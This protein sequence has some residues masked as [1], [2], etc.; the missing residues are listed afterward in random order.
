MLVFVLLLF[1]GSIY[2]KKYGS[3]S[4][5]ISRKKG[6]DFSGND[7]SGKHGRSRVEGEL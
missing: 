6:R 5:A 3:S 7:S 1:E 2:S 4:S